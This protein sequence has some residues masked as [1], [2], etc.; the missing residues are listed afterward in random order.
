MRNNNLYLNLANKGGSDIFFEEPFDSVASVEANGGSIN[1]VNIVSGIAEFLGGGQIS[2]IRYFP[3]VVQQI[4]VIVDVKMSTIGD[5]GFIGDRLAGTTDE[6]FD[7]YTRS[8]DTLY[9]LINTDG[10]T[11]GRLTISVST[12]GLNLTD[13]NYHRIIGTFDGT[14]SKLYVDG[15]LK[16][17]GSKSGTLN[18]SG[19]DFLIS[20]NAGRYLTGFM[21]YAAIYDYALTQ[22]EINNL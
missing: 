3:I 5:Y 2:S 6:T 4:S 7:L 22:E 13:G 21:D 15:V 12:T 8:I 14:T 19:N 10:T 9:W 20:G 18:S 11:G 1:N 17:S 16:A